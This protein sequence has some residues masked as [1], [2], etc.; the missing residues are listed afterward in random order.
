MTIEQTKPDEKLIKEQVKEVF[1]EGNDITEVKG[2]D[3]AFEYRWL[4]THKQNLEMKKARGWEV[5][6]DAKIKSFSGTPDS[7]HQI[8]DMLLARM[9][10]EKY[11]TMM[12]NKR[13]FGDARRKSVKKQYA[14]EGRII[15]I[16][17]FDEER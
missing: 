17:T 7:S 10:K 9:P 15:G 12:K 14:E 4:N 11:D 16:P 5:V 3:P 13:D 1:L 2:K 8:G 6:N